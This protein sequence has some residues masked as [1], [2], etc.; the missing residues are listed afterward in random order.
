MATGPR[1][2]GSGTLHQEGGRTR[3]NGIGGTPLSAVW[4]FPGAPGFLGLGW[5]TGWLSTVGGTPCQVTAPMRLGVIPM[6]SADG[7]TGHLDDI[8]LIGLGDA[9]TVIG[10]GLSHRLGDAEGSC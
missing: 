7:L 8:R 5:G 6:G 1:S 3:A 4:L 10:P 2:A 9:C